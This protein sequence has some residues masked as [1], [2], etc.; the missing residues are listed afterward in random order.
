MKKTLALLATALYLAGCQS[1]TVGVD[2]IDIIA[3]PVIALPIGDV[4]L[5]LDHIFTP[6]DSL[7]FA[8]NMD[9]QVVVA[10]D[11]VFALSVSDFFTLPSQSPSSSSFTMGTIPVS[12]VSMSN[13]ITLGNV[14]N[15]AS[16]TAINT[17]HGSNAPF[18]A[19]NQSNVGTY[20]SGG[21]SSFSTASFSQGTMSMTLTNDWPTTVSLNVD[22]VDNNTN[23]TL[24]SFVLAN[25]SANGGTVTDTESLVGV[26][27]SN[28]I[29]F[30]ISQLTAAS[31]GTTPVPID[32]TD[33]LTL[34]IATANLE[35]YSAVTTLSTQSLASDTQFVDLSAGA[36]RRL[37]ELMLNTAGFD[38][39]FVSSL[40]ENLEIEISFPGS[41]K[42]GVEVDTTITVPANDSV[43]GTLSLN[44]ATLDLTTD[45]NQNH[46]KLPIAVSATLQSS[47]TAVAVDS[48]D[49]LNMTFGMSNIDFG[50]VT[51]FFG[52]QT[53]NIANGSVPL[54]LDF[55]DNFGGSISF[56]D[57]TIGLNIT[58]SIGLPIELALNFD[59][60]S[61]GVASSLNGPNF[62]LPYPT[63]I[64][65]L[66][67]GTLAY[68]NTNSQI[69]SVFTL[70]K[71][72][73][74]YGGSI[75]VNHDTVTY[76]TNNFIT[77]DGAI[78][79]GLMMELPFTF[80]ASGL[81]LSD[82]LAEDL[83][84]GASVP[85]SMS[86][87]NIT[88]YLSTSTTLPLESDI[89]LRF[90]DSASTEI[91]TE[92][93]TLLDSGIPNVN[94]V[95]TTASVANNTIDLSGTD[96]D[97]VLNASVVTAEATM[98]TYNQ[99]SDPV[100]LRTDATIGISVGL[101]LEVSVTL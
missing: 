90:Y 82:T 86:V 21:F 68:D 10:Q 72:S 39:N 16:L 60:Y 53:I 8:D 69:A 97:N 19:V 74:V 56:T 44:G 27:L 20:G 28:D 6:D 87:E 46:S 17:A 11:S 99:G 49:G 79:G 5:T 18:P 26:T 54:S 52:T 73:I 84:L 1:D 93:I 76:G 30:K 36:G 3:E 45:P 70:P 96:L 55:L 62:V 2:D 58:N 25:A 50:H 43:S 41:D 14:A 4:N 94:G 71:D 13:A 100:K 57:P 101:Q 92:T 7:I 24:V 63:T 12:S 47:G 61:S 66:D 83:D 40:P 81:S 33:E 65:D 78:S 48:A 15:D 22:L 85:D 51:G 42:N 89:T 98:A 29:G 75:S 37:D 38:F 32:T 59:S 64:G 77:S 67:S 9:Y 91:H 31:T 23:T 88:L 95:V 80:T 34:D 35:V